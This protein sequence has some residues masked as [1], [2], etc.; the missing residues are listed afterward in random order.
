MDGFRQRQR[1]ARV[2]Y[3]RLI[4][5][6]LVIAVFGL[7]QGVWGVYQKERE[8][9]RNRERVEQQLAALSSREAELRDE[10]AYLR[11]ERGVEEEL[12]QQFEV[13]REGEEMLLIVERP[14]ES[15]ENE[16]EKRSWWQ[17]LWPF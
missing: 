10:L 17:A 11:T 5:L 14:V 16:S 3:R 4:T 15:T 8:T 9:S 13:G 6:V 12:R 2:W 7:A 1:V